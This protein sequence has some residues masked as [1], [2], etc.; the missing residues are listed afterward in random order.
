[1]Y[2]VLSLLIYTD[3]FHYY[4]FVQLKICATILMTKARRTVATWTS[5][6]QCSNVYR[7]QKPRRVATT[8][9]TQ[10]NMFTSLSDLL[11]DL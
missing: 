2:Y 10:S 1:M 5:H 7:G 11:S 4:L 9:L 8:P 3:I 6:V